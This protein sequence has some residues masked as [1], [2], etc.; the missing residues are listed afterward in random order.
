VVRGAVELVDPGVMGPA[1][2]RRY[3]CH[4]SVAHSLGLSAEGLARLRSLVEQRGRNSWHVGDV[5]V[6]VYGR[7]SGP[8][9][10]DGSR[11]AWAPSPTCSGARGRG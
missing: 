4:V 8:G 6:A 10:A 3:E 9:V 5:L 1:L 7:P 2:S 11:S